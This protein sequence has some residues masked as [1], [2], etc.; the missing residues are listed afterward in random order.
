MELCFSESGQE[1]RPGSCDGVNT[2][3]VAMA[4]DEEYLTEHN[5]EEN[6]HPETDIHCDENSHAVKCLIDDV[7]H[8]NNNASLSSEG[9][10][11]H[12]EV[13]NSAKSEPCVIDED[14]SIDIFQQDQG[15]ADG[16]ISDATCKTENVLDS[17]NGTTNLKANF[18]QSPEEDKSNSPVIEEEAPDK[19]DERSI[20]PSSKTEEPYF[21]AKATNAISS[22]EEIEQAA[23]RSLSGSN[24]SRDDDSL[25]TVIQGTYSVM[26]EFLRIWSVIPKF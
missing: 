13:T 3:A 4:T 24:I 18:E 25:V 12:E 26:L 14:S 22:D 9:F 6:T 5:Q 23:L 19:E 2:S 21:A 20:I 10:L 8:Y 17:V 16:I 1:D 11:P 15:C 7:S